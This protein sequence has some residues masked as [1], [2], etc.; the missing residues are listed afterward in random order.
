MTIFFITGQSFMK[1]FPEIKNRSSTYFIGLAESKAKMNEEE[2]LRYIAGCEVHSFDEISVK[3]GS[4]FYSKT[5]IC[6]FH[7]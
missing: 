5:E 4:N 1:E 3:F 7:Q 6:R 2:K